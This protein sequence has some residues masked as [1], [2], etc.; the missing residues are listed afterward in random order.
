MVL[1]FSTVSIKSQTLSSKIIDGKTKK[2]IPYATIQYGE[3]K[4]VISNEEGMFSF[5]IDS[6]AQRQD[7]IYISSLG[8]EKKGVVFNNVLDSIIFITPK[9][10]ELSGVYVF[11]KDLSI[12]EILDKMKNNLSKNYKNSYLKKRFF[13][14]QSY[15]DRLKK[16]NVK[17]KKSTIKE[18]NKKLIDS[19]ISVVP[20]KSSY[21]TETLGDFYLSPNKDIAN[22]LAIVKAAELY[23]KNNEISLEAL[24]ERFEKIL[25]KSVKKDSYL[26]IK[27]GLFSTKVQVDSLLEN[28]EDAQSLQENATPEKSNFLPNKKRAMDVIHNRMWAKKT[29]LDVVKKLNRYKFTLQGYDDIENQGVYVLNFEPKWRGD[30]EGTIYVNI[31][32]FA[33][34]RIDY[35]NVKNLRNFKLLGFSQKNHTYKGSNVYTKTPNGDYTIKFST[36]TFGST[37]GVKRPLK[38]IEKNKHVKGRRKQNELKVDID[39]VNE[40]YSTSQLVVYDIE[41]SNKTT[42]NGITENKK[43]KPSYLPA[44]NPEFWKGFNIIEP[45]QAIREFSAS[46]SD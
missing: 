44:Y 9:A 32:D 40:L 34:M 2:P 33:I 38:I 19:V 6:T 4:G 18:L 24:Q 7:S 13:L 10:V 23:D 36:F 29:N 25:N 5:T 20:R 46:E 37:T 39:F 45:N 8:Y 15:H 14:R 27:S 42:L 41:N 12:D 21:Y 30:F 43:I 26:K 22:K 31:E 1:I 28:S 16:M 17:F 11:K 35:K 3:N